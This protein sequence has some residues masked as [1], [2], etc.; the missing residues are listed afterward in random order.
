MAETIAFYG[1]GMLGSG[2][3]KSLRRHGY[4]VHVWNR[5][6]ENALHLEANGA[7]VFSDAADAA[8]GASRVHICVRDD[9]SVD[10][11]LDQALPG[12]AQTAAI[13]D[14][15][16]VLPENVPGRAA[17]LASSGY[18]FMHAPVFMSPAGAAQS[19]GTMLV[20]GPTTLY[21]RMSS[22][23]EQMAGRVIYFGEQPDIA[24]VYKLMGNSIILGLIGTVKDTFSIGEANGLKPSEAYRLFD[25]FSPQAQIDG[26]VKRMSQGDF[27][28]M[29]GLDM[30]HKDAQL[31]LA[32]APE[33][34]L[35][36]IRTVERELR[37]ASD[38]GL[39]NKDL[40]AVLEARTTAA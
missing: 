8:R 29:W 10:A 14:H 11:V 23:L 12:I 32:A 27:A 4:D 7:K 2:F 31:M 6:R 26:R 20:S 37:S 16:T 28:P 34:N 9:A 38:Q 33:R 1:T 35:P 15:T 18:A 22:A 3:V 5:T 13:V 39:G 30:A 17:R 21:E 36:V 25:F 19:D 40:G 24:A